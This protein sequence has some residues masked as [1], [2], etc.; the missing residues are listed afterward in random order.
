MSNQFQPS[1]TCVAVHVSA[2][3]GFQAHWLPY[4]QTKFY[5]PLL[6]DTRNGDLFRAVIPHDLRSVAFVPAQARAPRT[7]PFARRINDIESGAYGPE[8]LLAEFAAFVG[9]AA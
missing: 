8:H 7:S 6:V 3:G 2:C 5:S 9:G 4:G 1:P